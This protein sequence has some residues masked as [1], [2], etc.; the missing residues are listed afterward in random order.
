MAKSL[1]SFSPNAAAAAKAALRSGPGKAGRGGS[2]RITLRSDEEP[3]PGGGEAKDAA[4]ALALAAE[5]E[6]KDAADALAL[7]AKKIRTGAVGDRR[8]T[9]AFGDR[10]FL[11]SGRGRWALFVD[12]GKLESTPKALVVSLN[13]V[14]LVLGR[15]SVGLEDI[16]LSDIL[17]LLCDLAAGGA[18]EILLVETDSGRALDAV[19]IP[20]RAEGRIS[21][22]EWRTEEGGK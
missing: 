15:T 10:V 11:R 17:L 12:A 22:A 19:A 8:G 2:V 6:A 1:D 14:R 4:D 13:E 16:P 5:K 7:A 20:L 3:I 9:L 18:E 21:D